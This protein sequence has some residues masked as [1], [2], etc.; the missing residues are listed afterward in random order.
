MNPAVSI[1]DPMELKGCAIGVEP[2]HALTARRSLS[3]RLA[4]ISRYAAPAL[5]LPPSTPK[6]L[7]GSI[8][9]EE[10]SLG[11]ITCGIATSTVAPQIEIGARRSLSAITIPARNAFGAADAFKPTT[12]SRTGNTQNYGTPS[13]TARRFA[14]PATKRLI[15]SAGPSTGTANLVSATASEIAAKRLSQE[16]L[17][18]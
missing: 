2:R 17:A 3:L 8:C 9:T 1:S 16:V 10:Q 13:L 5:A 15:R 12:S 18:L 11:L 14:F 6:E 4:T 7:H